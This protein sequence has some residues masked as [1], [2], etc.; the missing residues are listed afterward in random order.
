MSSLKSISLN[1]SEK[2]QR[3]EYF[4]EFFG[5]RAQDEVAEQIR[6]L[7]EAL[8]MTQ[9]ALAE[10]CDMK[11]SAL[12]RLES[13]DYSG[14][15]FK[16]LRRVSEALDARLKISFEPRMA[17]IEHYRNMELHAQGLKPVEP[18]SVSRRAT[19]QYQ[20]IAPV[21][22][23]AQNLTPLRPLKRVAA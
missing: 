8:G 14:W 21:G 6:S 16:T 22:V 17:V 19:D 4:H 9:A 23:T 3:P 11:Q 18:V 12:S 2:F 15:S 13:A 7:R 1:L 5:G 10:K 20:S